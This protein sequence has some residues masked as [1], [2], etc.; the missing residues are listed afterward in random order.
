VIGVGGRAERTI[1]RRVLCDVIE[2]RI[3]ETLNFVNN[4]IKKSGLSDQLGAGLVLTGGA[5]QMDGV[6]ELSE[7]IFDMP[8]RQG[9]PMHFGGLTDVVS[10]PGYSTVLGVLLHGAEND[11]GRGQTISTTS[12]FL[13]QISNKLKNFIDE[14]F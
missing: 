14:A 7:F 1:M 10:S 11:K 9:R 2:P 8:V 6:I 13:G 12:G 5:S 3:E 4:E